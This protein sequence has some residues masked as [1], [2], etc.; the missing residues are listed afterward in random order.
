MTNAE[1][2]RTMT[3]AE[4][5]KFIR[6]VYIEGHFYLPEDTERWLRSDSQTGCGLLT[7]NIKKYWKVH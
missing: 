2:I 1:V 7:E 3:T 4:L 6:A 5:G